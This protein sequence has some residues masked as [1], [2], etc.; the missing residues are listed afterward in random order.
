MKTSRGALCNG[1]AGPL[2]YK[3]SPCFLTAQVTKR[4]FARLYILAADQP[5]CHE[6]IGPEQKVA[7]GGPLF[8]G[9]KWTRGPVTDAKN[10]PGLSKVDP[11]LLINPRAKVFELEFVEMEMETSQT[12]NLVE[13]DSEDVEGGRD[14]VQEAYVYLTEHRYPPGC[15]SSRKRSIRKKAGKFVVREGEMFFKKK[16]KGKVRSSADCFG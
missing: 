13:N 8:A 11:P 2:S 15:I 5:A 4:V 3:R 1:T 7:R 6:K 16:R 10:G 9:K 12:S 14:L